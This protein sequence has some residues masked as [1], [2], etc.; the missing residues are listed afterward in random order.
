M[1]MA[2]RRVLGLVLVGLLL[3]SVVGLAA[4]QTFVNK[5]G[6]TVTGITI[7]FFKKVT[8]TRHDLAF[9]DQSPSG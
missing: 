6:K 1:R 3:M 9:P 5:S 8:I 4:S 7:T 2:A